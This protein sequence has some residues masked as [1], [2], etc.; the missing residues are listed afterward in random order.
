MFKN[1]QVAGADPL[2][3]VRHLVPQ[4][5]DPGQ[6]RKLLGVGKGAPGRR[7]RPPGTHQGFGGV[8]GVIPVMRLFDQPPAGGD[9][10][11]IGAEDLGEAG[12]Q[13]GALA[14]QQIVV[15]GLADERMPERVPVLVRAQHVGRHRG[16]QP[17]GEIVAGQPGR[18]RQQGVPAVNPLESIKISVKDTGQ[19][20][21]ISGLNTKQFV[22]TMEIAPPK[23]AP[24][25]LPPATT[26]LP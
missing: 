10:P 25:G 19:S 3:C 5:E 26:T 15:D 14:G 24:A 9:Q 6:K 18:R 13:P 4:L 21:V 16:A 2:H 20:K 11:G 7:G 22:L 12:V 8:V 1:E 23:D 17:A